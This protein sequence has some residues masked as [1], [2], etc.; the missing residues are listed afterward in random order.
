VKEVALPDPDEDDNDDLNDAMGRIRLRERKAMERKLAK[1]TTK[2]KSSGNSTTDENN[3]SEQ[4]DNDDD[5][6]HESVGSYSS[7]PKIGESY[8]DNFDEDDP[9]LKA[10]GG[11][12]QLLT[13]DAYR[14][15]LLQQQQQ[16]LQ[17]PSTT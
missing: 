15:K 13:G 12:D 3:D 9:F 16:H 11:V 14:Q 2:P 1:E 17:S 5:D 8:D 6:G 7:V 10:I 4:H